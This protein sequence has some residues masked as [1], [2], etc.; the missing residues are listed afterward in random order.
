MSHNGLVDVHWIFRRRGYLWHG[1]LDCAWFDRVTD[2][3]S[4]VN[5]LEAEPSTKLE[6]ALWSKDITR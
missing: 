5:L 1:D 2:C 6:F 3:N 4:Y